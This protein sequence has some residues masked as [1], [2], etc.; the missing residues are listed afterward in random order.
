[1]PQGGRVVEYCRSQ[2]VVDVSLFE[3][4][5]LTTRASK[6]QNPPSQWLSTKSMP[7]A[8]KITSIIS[9]CDGCDDKARPTDAALLLGAQLRTRR[10]RRKQTGPSASGPARTAQ[11]SRGSP[12]QQNNQSGGVDARYCVDRSLS[13]SRIGASEPV[14]LEASWALTDARLR[15]GLDMRSGATV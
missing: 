6:S 1:M 11:D 8:L 14:S 9:T 4:S 3:V 13:T 2:F 10:H 15:F 5:A 7:N 12:V